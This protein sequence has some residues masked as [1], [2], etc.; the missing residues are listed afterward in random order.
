MFWLVP[1]TE[2]MHP[3]AGICNPSVPA[4]ASKKGCAGFS[5]RSDVKDSGER[6]IY[7][8]GEWYTEM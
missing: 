8:T 3:N 2:E 4:Q 6:T 1:E 5:L 7:V